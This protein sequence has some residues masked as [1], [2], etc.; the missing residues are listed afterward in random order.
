MEPILLALLYSA[1]YDVI[2]KQGPLYKLGNYIYTKLSARPRGELVTLEH[3][4]KRLRE[5]SGMEEW[6]ER[7]VRAINLDDISSLGD[8]L[9]EKIDQL[10]D[11]ENLDQ[12]LME[13]KKLATEDSAIPL[14]VENVNILLEL[15]QRIYDDMAKADQIEEVRNIAVATYNLVLSGQVSDVEKFQQKISQP[16]FALRESV[17]R[18]FIYSVEDHMKYSHIQISNNAEVLLIRPTP[19]ITATNRHLYGIYLFGWANEI[20]EVLMNTDHHLIELAGE[21]ATKAEFESALDKNPGIE[22]VIYYG[23]GEHEALMGS[24][25][26]AIIDENNIHLLSG[27]IAYTVCCRAGT[28]LAD[29]AISSGAQA[30]FGYRDALYIA[31]HVDISLRKCANHA[32]IKLLRQGC[33]VYEAAT[34]MTETYRV[35]IDRFEQSQE[36]ADNF[37][38]ISAAVLRSNLSSLTSSFGQGG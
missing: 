34:R 7:F 37:W 4:F 8:K 31:P 16:D 20:I 9:I 27:K 30:F 35:W 32:I 38:F 11:R 23:Y 36:G 1:T 24:D 18:E 29:M 26:E 33:D 6:H 13:I 17:E 15:G 19:S 2:K 3:M 21:Y 5:D 12:I 28:G 10:G 14:L 22:A 25:N